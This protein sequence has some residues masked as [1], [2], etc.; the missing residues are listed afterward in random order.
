MAINT[1][2]QIKTG[3]SIDSLNVS[4][5]SG[6]IHD[7]VAFLQAKEFSWK[8]YGYSNI[9][10][11]AY[12][13]YDDVTIDLFGDRLETDQE[14]EARISYEKKFNKSK[15]EKVE[16]KEKAEK[17]LYARLKKKYDKKR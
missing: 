11:D 9:R 1:E 7:V 15:K 14:L 6:N 3:I 16:E 2:K 17:A 10:I 5:F 8:A 12:Q 4:D 13:H